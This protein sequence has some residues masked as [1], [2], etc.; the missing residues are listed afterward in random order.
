MPGI[1]YNETAVIQT[2]LT[3]LGYPIIQ[4]INAG[5]AGAE[6][7]HQVYNTVLAADLSSP[8]WRFATKVA[9]LSQIAGVDPDFMG[10]NTAYQI[11]PD[12]LAIW[13]IWPSVPY[14]VF[15]ERIWTT[16]SQQLQMQYRA[17]VPPSMLPPAYIMYLCYLLAD[18]ISAGKTEDAKVMQ[19][20]E[21]GMTKWRSQAMVVNSQGR[22]NTS[23][24]NSPWVSSRQS[25][26]PFYGT[27][28]GF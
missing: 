14:E 21:A 3:I 5:G 17:M 18:T 20:I 22:P 26:F 10:F 6:A 4:S 23:L 16:G 8:N 28:G 7:L 13:Q 12:C 1:P 25:G 24:G 11:P 19:K 27:G 9:V 15:G 2:A